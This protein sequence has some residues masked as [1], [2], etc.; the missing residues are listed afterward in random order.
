[1]TPEK[2]KA[3]AGGNPGDLKNTDSADT[4]SKPESQAQ[5]PFGAHLRLVASDA[6]RREREQ[7]ELAEHLAHLGGRHV[8]EAL[9]AVRRGQTVISV[10]QDFQTLPRW[11]GLRVVGVSR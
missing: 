10:L 1:M 9:R 4:H 2:E 5:A 6:N 3:A 7:I 8:L 11:R